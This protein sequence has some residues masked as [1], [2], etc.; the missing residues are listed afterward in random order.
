MGKIHKLQGLRAIAALLVVLD[1]ALTVIIGHPFAVH[2]LEDFSWFIGEQG[3][4]TFFVISG[5]IM[6]YTT[7][8]KFEKPLAAL[9]FSSQ[10]L[11]RIVPL[12]WLGT[13]FAILLITTHLW[14]LPKSLTL[15]TIV[16]S[17]ALVPY[18]EGDGDIRPIL[19]QGWTLTYELM[20]YAVF[21]VALGLKRSHGLVFICLILSSWVIVG[22]LA[23]LSDWTQ[24]PRTVLGFLTSPL[25][26]LFLVGI[27]IGIAG[28]KVPHRWPL[29]SLTLSLVLYCILAAAFVAFVAR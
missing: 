17:L 5:F 27:G 3:V 25:I 7:W 26:L 12:Y 4:A 10:R 6:T 28:K 22:R 14:H 13:I 24:S 21:A 15:E 11:I 9:D 16:K 1:H 2:P 19:G 23:G 18:V 20:F 8:N 29:P